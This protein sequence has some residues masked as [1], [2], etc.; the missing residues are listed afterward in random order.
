MTPPHFNTYQSLY[1]NPQLQQQYPPSQYG[2]IYPTQH[3]SSTYPSQSQF[4][5]SSV[6]PSYPY[7]SQMN[8][9]T[10]YVLQIAYQSPQVSIQPMTESPL[11]DS[12]FD[13][14][15]FS[16]G[17]DLIAC[18]NKA[19]TFLTA[20]A[21]SRFPLTNNQLRTSWNPRNQSTIQDGRVTVQQVQGR[22]GQSYSGTGYKSNA[23][24]SEENNACRQARVV[25]CY[26]CQGEGHIT[27]Q[28]TQPKRPRNA[29]WYKEKAMLAKAQE[30]RQILDEEQ[31]AFL[32]DPGVPD[33]EAVLIIILNN[34][35]FQNEDRDTYDS[36]CDDI[37]NAK[38]ILI[39]NISNY[40]SNIILEL[41]HSETYLNDM[42]NQ[43]VHAMQDFKQI[44][45]VDFTDNEIH[46][47]SNIIPYSQ[48]LQETQLADVQDTNLQ[49]QQDSMILYVIEKISEQMI[50]HVN[51]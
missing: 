26:N 48:Y 17:D 9:Q 3:Y 8:H 14:P 51:N 20:V 31:L 22:Q 42:E 30:A 33:D 28:C 12:G 49:A 21:S 37:S 41:P 50:N 1:N 13:V 19:M 25:K 4:N 18:L 2:L 46:S 39:A 47:D 11:G 36:D 24:S 45:T 29:A 34:V 40:G 27:R 15:V 10:S 35:A 6:P 7:Q 32:A 43:S 44:P 5:H 23:T 38:A 16:P